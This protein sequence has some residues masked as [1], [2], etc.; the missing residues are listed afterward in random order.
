MKKAVTYG[1]FG[2]SLVLLN[3]SLVSYGFKSP[4][5]QTIIP[6]NQGIPGGALAV[7]SA[8][9]FAIAIFLITET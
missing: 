8:A 1:L 7:A 3:D 9:S 5:D 6:W 4:V 2:F